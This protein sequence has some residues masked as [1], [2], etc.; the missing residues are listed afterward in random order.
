MCRLQNRSMELKM[1]SLTEDILNGV[2]AG[3]KILGFK[4]FS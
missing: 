2:N 1:E 4:D 3:A